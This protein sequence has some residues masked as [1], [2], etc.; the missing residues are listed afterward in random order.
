MK[1][2]SKK[3][4]FAAM[5]HSCKVDRGAGTFADLELMRSG[6]EAKGHGL[7]IDAKT[8]ETFVAAVTARGGRLKG[9]STHN[10]EGPAGAFSWSELDSELDIVG[11]FEGVADSKGV[12]IAKAFS[13]YESFKKYHAEEYEKLLEIAERTPDLISLSVEVWGYTVF[14]ST[15]G[16]EFSE[17]PKDVDLANEGMPT[18]RV[19]DAFAAAFVSDGAATDGLFA[20]FGRL[21][22]VFGNK[23]RGS[24][25]PHSETA[26]YPRTH[27][28]DTDSTMSIIKEIKTRF[29]A[30]PA[31]IKQA[32]SIIADDANPESLTLSTIEARLA[33]AE[34]AA[35]TAQLGTVTKERDELKTK[36]A[37]AEK[38]LAELKL[39][40]DALKGSGH[41]GQ[42]NLGAASDGATGS[43]A[44]INPWKQGAENLTEQARILKADPERAKALK[45]AAAAK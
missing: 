43:T 19:T 37:T 14:V 33:T 31:K 23:P 44:E 3:I 7:Y 4:Q 27:S 21:F 10:H 9:Y 40:F 41:S 24:Q 39:K 13:F 38:E 32:L 18:L 42:V 29:S 6:R 2:N 15:D 36:L 22:S 12:A 1:P 26:L 25:Q 8:I 11:Y 45:A 28:E 5:P 16:T 17:R 34:Q 30:D 20:K 35:I